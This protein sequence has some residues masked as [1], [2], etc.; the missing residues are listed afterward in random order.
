MEDWSEE[1][2]N[3]YFKKLIDQNKGKSYLPEN[4]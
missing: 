3:Q 2:E 4:R 1:V